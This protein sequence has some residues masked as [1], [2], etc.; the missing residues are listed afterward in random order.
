[1]MND[2]LEKIEQRI[3]K[4][5]DD[6]FKNNPRFKNGNKKS[7]CSDGEFLTWCSEHGC[8]G[9]SAYTGRLEI[10][11]F[12]IMIHNEKTCIEVED[13]ECVISRKDNMLVRKTNSVYLHSLD[14]L[15]KHVNELLLFE[16]QVKELTSLLAAK[17]DF[18]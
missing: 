18:V 10:A 17:E 13:L 15:T 12:T 14:E 1:M 2:E 3:N 11:G 4:I 9:Y 6:Y 8:T 16:K 5:L 7:V